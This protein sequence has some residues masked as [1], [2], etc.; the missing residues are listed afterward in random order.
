[1]RRN[2]EDAYYD[3]IKRIPL[4]TSEE[5]ITCGRSVQAMLRL[6]HAKPQGPYTRVEQQILRRGKKAKNRMISANLR[7]VAIIARKNTRMTF[8]MTFLDLVQEGNI[9][10]IKAVERYD[11][12]RGYKFSTY[13]YWWIRQHINRSMQTKD[14]LIRVPCN[15]LESLTKLRKWAEDFHRTR[16]RK[17][18]L[19]ESASFLA[20][21]EEQLTLLLERYPRVSSLDASLDADKETHLIELI[22]DHTQHAVLDMASQRQLYDIA[23]EAIERLPE[24]ERMIMAEAYGLLGKP[25]STLVEIA[26]SQSVSSEAIRQQIARISNKIRHKCELTMS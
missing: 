7:L 8:S 6:Q 16:S 19:Q 25:A 18:T 15:G 22:P 12:E 13:A 10:L 4:L 26:K 9:G 5:E 23:C 2:T 11:P 20:I 3:E 21:T 24:Q 17:P 1:M 14:R